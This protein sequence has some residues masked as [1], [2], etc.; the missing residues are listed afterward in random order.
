MRGFPILHWNWILRLH[1]W[2]PFGRFTRGA[3]VFL[4]PPDGP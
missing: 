1:L 3:V 2:R 4:M